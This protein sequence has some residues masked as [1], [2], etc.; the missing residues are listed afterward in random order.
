MVVPAVEELFRIAIRH[1]ELRGCRSQGDGKATWQ[2]TL[3]SSAAAS[4]ACRHSFPDAPGT[5]CHVSL[6]FQSPSKK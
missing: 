5:S 6:R 3:T 1:E 2:H 4:A